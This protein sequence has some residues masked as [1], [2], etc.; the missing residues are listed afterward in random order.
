MHSFIWCQFWQIYTIMHVHIYSRDAWIA[1]EWVNG[2]LAVRKNW[3]QHQNSSSEAWEARKSVRIS[4]VEPDFVI[5]HVGVPRIT[6]LLF[7]SK[8]NCK[9]IPLSIV[10]SLAGGDFGFPETCLCLSMVLQH[11]EFSRQPKT[12]EENQHCKLQK[13][14]AIPGKLL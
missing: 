2:W 1:A 10:S 5:I 11:N 9:R 8:Q 7:L 3:G 14:S 13:I 4:E 6:L 12:G